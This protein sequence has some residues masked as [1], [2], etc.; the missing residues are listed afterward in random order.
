MG[1][2]FEVLALSE[3][4][5]QHGVPEGDVHDDD[6]RRS[7][8]SRACAEDGGADGEYG[9]PILLFRKYR[10][11]PR[12]GRDKRA[13]GEEYR[14]DVLLFVAAVG[15]RAHYVKLTARSYAVCD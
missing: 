2:H 8:A 11:R 15:R 7:R 10:G 14:A 6:A 1:L 12:R 9:A 13:A 4:Q 3:S 5:G